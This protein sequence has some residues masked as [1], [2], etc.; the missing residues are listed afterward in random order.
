MKRPTPDKIPC[1]AL[2]IFRHYPGAATFGLAPGYQH[3]APLG[4]V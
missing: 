3:A 4:L 1:G 2:P